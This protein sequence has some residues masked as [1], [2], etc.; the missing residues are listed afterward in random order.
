MRR[1]FIHEWPDWPRFVLY[2]AI[3]A[4][5]LGQVRHKQGRLIGH[6]GA[7]G[8]KL[9]QEAVLGTL[10]T[11]VIKSSEIEGARLDPEQV[12]SSIARHLGIDVGA[13]KA[14]DR[15]VEGIVQI[16]LDATGRYEEPLTEERLLAWHAALFLAGRSGLTK[17][18]VGCWR[19]DSTGPMQVVSGPMGKERVHFVAPG[20][21]RLAGEMQTFLNWFNGQEELD[22]VVKGDWR[23]FGS[24]L[25]IRWMT[26][27][28]GLRVP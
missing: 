9:R 13:L 12:R 2:I 15:H 7:L 26:A 27:T 8:F 23:I 14:P 20:A 19:D 4:E 3:L 6:M 10:T 1:L 22:P 5:P 28:G 11:D 16:M 17:V 18:R 25:F 24:S 21:S